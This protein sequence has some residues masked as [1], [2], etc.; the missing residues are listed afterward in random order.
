M[1]RP[2]LGLDGENAAIALALEYDY[3]LLID[4]AN[5]YHRAKAAGLK[6]VGSNEFAVLLYDHGRITYKA[7]SAA[8][9]QTHASKKQKRLALVALETLNRYKEN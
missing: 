5:P 2:L 7:A 1:R 9:R 4:D 3:F 6:V 8:I